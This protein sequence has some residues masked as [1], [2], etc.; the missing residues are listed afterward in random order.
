[1]PSTMLFSV[2]IG[3]G[4]LAFVWFVFSNLLVLVNPEK[5]F[6]D[7]WID[8]PLPTWAFQKITSKIMKTKMDT[9]AKYWIQKSTIFHRNKCVSFFAEK[10]V[11][12]VSI[13]YFFSG[14][15]RAASNHAEGN[16]WLSTYFNLTTPEEIP[17]STLFIIFLLRN[18]KPIFSKKLWDEI[19]TIILFYLDAFEREMFAKLRI[20]CSSKKKRKQKLAIYWILCIHYFP[21][22]QRL[23]RW[24]RVI[25][26]SPG[27]LLKLMYWHDRWRKEDRWRSFVWSMEPKTSYEWLGRNGYTYPFLET[28][29][30]P[31]KNSEPSG[32]NEFR[33][34]GMWN[35]VALSFGI[36]VVHC[37]GQLMH[38]GGSSLIP[39]LLCFC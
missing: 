27:N 28:I 16:V 2:G 4:E 24:E 23:Q 3:F 32:S 6:P 21:A 18:T 25:E 10:R 19:R 39:V 35:I 37:Y 8:A 34:L 15:D 14:C 26:N 17:P 38:L 9:H 12:H 22:N 13:F 30:R 29:Y 33:F 7:L 31:E 11:L 36:L 20:K 1:M 5:H